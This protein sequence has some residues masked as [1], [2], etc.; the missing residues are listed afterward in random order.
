M[1]VTRP[2]V[3]VLASDVLFQHF[4]P[5]AALE[6]LGAATEWTRSSLREDSTELRH[7]I[8]TA[9]VLMTTWHSPFLTPDMLGT[10]SSVKLIAHCGG[11]V[12]S[13]IAES[14]FDYVTVTNA[15]DPMSRGVAEMTLA[16]VLTLVRRIPEYANEMRKGVIRTNEQVS[17]GETLFGRKVGIVGF[18]RIGRTFAQLLKPFNLEL[19]VTDPYAQQNVAEVNNVRLVE[20]DELVSSC[21]VVVLAAAL[22]PE[23]RHLFDKRRLGLL[24][25]GSYLINV[26]RGG[27]IDNQALVEELKSGR[28]TAA[29]DVTDPLEPLPENHELRKLPNIILTPHIAAGGLEMRR[30]IGMLAV[31]E[32][33]RFSNGQPPLNR[34]TR[35]ML[36]TMT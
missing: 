28:I 17:E 31:E 23:T 33:V 25:D 6:K 3:L 18:G 14:I 5:S 15:A 7:E 20:L 35:E 36:A 4:F 30:E 13:R 8:S 12:K 27:L 19:L 2:N 26:A 22:T 11:E 34:V 9:D 10:K 32:V 16:L 1:K 24:L 21:S 29:L